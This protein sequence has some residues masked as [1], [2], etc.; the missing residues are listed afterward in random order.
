MNIYYLR[1]ITII[2]YPLCSQH[3]AL[4]KI[5]RDKTVCNAPSKMLIDICPINSGQ[6]CGI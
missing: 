5:T 6:I 2:H 4:D 3:I 1:C